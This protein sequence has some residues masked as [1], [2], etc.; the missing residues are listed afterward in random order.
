L[1]TGTG[2]PPEI[3]DRIFEP[4]SLLK[5]VGKGTG[6]GLS[7]LVGIIKSHGGFIS[8]DSLVGKGSQFKVYLPAV[9]AAQSSRQKSLN[10]PQDTE[11]GF[12][13]WTSPDSRDYK[14]ALEAHNYKVL[15]ASGIEAIELYAQHKD[16][17]SVVLTDMMMMDGSTTIRTLQK[18]NPQIKIIAAS[19]LAS[20]D[21]VAEAAGLGIKAFCRSPTQRENIEHH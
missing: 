15:T 7:I 8:V 9:S 19:G 5:E 10:C 4:F 1:D 2:I 21:K 12:W 3:L 17:I 20:N 11:K 18:M 6:L 13:L 16:E 14:T